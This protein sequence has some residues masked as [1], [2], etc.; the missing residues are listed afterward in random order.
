MDFADATLV[1]L[2]EDLGTSLV[3]TTDARTS[4]STAS[5]DARPSASSLGDPWSA[6]TEFV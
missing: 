3:F 6:L 5:K 2:A 4:P 1:V